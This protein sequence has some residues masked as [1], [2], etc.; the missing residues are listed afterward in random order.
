[1]IELKDKIR[2]SIFK[3][4]RCQRNWDLSKKIPKED[5][6]LIVTSATECPTKQNIEFYNLHVIQDRDIIEDI[7]DKTYFE[8][9]NEEGRTNPQ[10]LANALLVFSENKLNN[11]KNQENINNVNDN[12]SSQDKITIDEDL[13]QAVGIAAGFVNLTA[14]MLDYETGCCK[15]FNAEEVK[16]ILG[17]E[18]NPV[19]LMGVGMKDSTKNR[20]Q[21]HVTDDMVP[22]YN[23]KINVIYA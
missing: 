14:S 22:S 4:Q 13:H 23:K 20:R 10:V 3:S 1:M 2:K 8:N 15:C 17:T 7:H 12:M 9:E 5:L 6:D 19:L 18:Y 11:V 16:K 21:H